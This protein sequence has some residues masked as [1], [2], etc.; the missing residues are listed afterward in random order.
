[1]QPEARITKKIR[2]FLSA[3]PRSFFFK[4]HGSAAMMAGLPDLIGCLEGKFVGV[5]VKQPGQKPSKIQ[6][7]VHGRIRAA[8]GVVI[9]A[10][11]LDDVQHLVNP[12]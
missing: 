9:V 4:I 1:M 3:H 8:G 5:E 10:T 7:L 2:E 12:P 11:S 6:N